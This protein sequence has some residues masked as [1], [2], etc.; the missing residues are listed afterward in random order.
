MA[1]KYNPGF[2][3]DFLLE[4]IRDFNVTLADA[5]DETRP[6]LSGTK[7]DEFY[8]NWLNTD[9]LL[10]TSI[11]SGFIALRDDKGFSTHEVDEKQLDRLD[12]LFQK[13][14][15]FGFR[16]AYRHLRGHFNSFYKRIS[17]KPKGDSPDR[18]AR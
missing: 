6:L 3:R 9:L 17:P 11:G 2:A 13:G 14:M 8:Q 5:I 15:D 12:E 4:L 10:H 1:E 18:K 7:A 16:K